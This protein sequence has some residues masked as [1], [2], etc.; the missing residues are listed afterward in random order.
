VPS[1]KQ[2]SKPVILGL[3]LSRRPSKSAST[4]DIVN[5]EL[6]DS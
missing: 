2:V 5:F 3:T 4:V 1:F 6:A